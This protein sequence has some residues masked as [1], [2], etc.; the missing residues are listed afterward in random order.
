MSISEKL[1][2]GFLATL[3]ALTV[4]I[5]LLNL[6]GGIV[7]GIWL[8]ILG[9]WG[10][11]VRGI[12]FLVISGFAI[13]FALMPGLLFAG[14]AAMAMERGKK[15]LGVF[16]GS[17]SVLYTVA[18]IT[19]WCIWVFWLFVSSAT[20]SSL[21]PLLIW[22]Y[23]VALGPW[24]WLAQKDQQGGGNEFST[25]TT[26]FAQ[27]AYILG[28]IMFFFGATLGTI[29]IAF[30][31]IMLSG[32]ILQMVIA[33]G[34]EMKK[35]FTPRGIKEALG[36]LDE[37]G[38]TIGGSG[39]DLVKE[40]IEKYLVSHSKKY[41]EAVK[42]TSPRQW[43]YSAVANTAGDLLESGHYHIYRGVLNPMGPGEDLLKLFDSAID[44]LVKMGAIE[45]GDAKKEK[46][47]VRKN[48]EAMG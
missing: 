38:Q 26:F 21:I 35:S 46:A 45:A 1:Q 30:G 17:L 6:L 16:F 41:E 19:V 7:S 23:G 28:M 11:I 15:I 37:I 24:M 39:F 14:P 27:A 42:K 48:I 31:T 43:V 9:E 33:F 25:L 5:A 10:E 20:E 2:T 3:T 13:S 44:E 18:L 22:S 12:I 29:A 32:A 34:G 36:I 47:A 40:P 4:P 8:A